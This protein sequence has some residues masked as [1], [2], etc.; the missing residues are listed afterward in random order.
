MYIPGITLEVF[1]QRIIKCY[2]YFWFL[3]NFRFLHASSIKD[4][5]VEK[6]AGTIKAES[7]SVDRPYNTENPPL[8]LQISTTAQQD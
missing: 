1:Y 3:R 5:E 7:G 4:E 2:E 8:S 6:V